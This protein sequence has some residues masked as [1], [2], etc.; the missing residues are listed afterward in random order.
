[1]ISYYEL[2][3][4]IKEGKEPKRLRVYLTSTQSKIYCAEN[5]IDNTFSYYVIE[6]EGE[7]NENFKYY[8]GECFLESDMF[9]KNIEILDKKEIEKIE[10]DTNGI[11][12]RIVWFD[13]RGKHH[14][15]TN[16]KDKFFANKINEIIDIIEELREGKI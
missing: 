3:T 6:N 13:E 10:F 9:D 15:N 5:D 12:E 2:L 16:T 8:L 14:F 4:M 7:E 1:M 11:D